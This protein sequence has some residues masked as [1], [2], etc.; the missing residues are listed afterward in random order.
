M[1]RF[2][3]TGLG[4][5]SGAASDLV[6]RT[7]SQHGLMADDGSL[8][9]GS[10]SFAMPDLGRLGMGSPRAD[11]S[12]P[13]VPDGAE[14]K[15]RT[16]TCDAGSRDIVTYVPAAAGT[17]ATGLVVMLHG[18]TQTADDFA[19]GTGMNALADKHGFV[20][21]YPEQ[22][23]GANAQTCWNWFSRGDQRR[24]RGEPAIIAAL[25]RDLAAEHG[26][27][28]GA[29]FAAGLSAGGAMAVILGETYPDVFSAIGVHSGLPYQ[30]ARDVQSAFS[31]MRGD[32]QDGPA[33][34]KRASTRTIL[35]HGSADHTVA[36][37]NGTRIGRDVLD[38][39]QGSAVQ[40]VETGTAN[41]LSYSRTVS[42]CGGTPVLEEW[43]I[44][45][46]GHAWSGGDPAGS[47]TDRR[48][49]AASAECVR[50]FFNTD[51]SA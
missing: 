15:R 25:A 49:P 48:G 4:L 6:R 36:P 51:G 17:H 1:K 33:G 9:G 38:A 44:D 40:T 5:H 10:H 32:P 43:V 14:Y 41:G 21:A 23:R 22:S 11:T 35:F 47:Y 20:V 34:T 28:S 42:M 39:S 3:P 18:C 46:L 30:S 50:F 31:A 7:L 27:P 19:A 2:N 16:F 12:I 26:I 37:M 8:P 13:T 24:D 29:V 45:G